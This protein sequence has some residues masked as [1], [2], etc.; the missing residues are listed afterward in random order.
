M[1][2]NIT[3]IGKRLI[4]CLI[5]ASIIIIQMPIA[6]CYADNSNRKYISIVADGT[7]QTL[8]V[9]EKGGTIFIN[10]EDIPSIARYKTDDNNDKTISYLLGS[11]SIV[12]NK[13]DGNY[14]VY[15]LYQ[16]VMSSKG[17][18]SN[19]ISNE[20]GFFIPLAEILPWLNTNVSDAE[21]K[22]ILS[23]DTYSIWELVG[24]DVNRANCYN[25]MDGMDLNSGWTTAG[26]VTLSTIH[27]FFNVK[28]Q[29]FIPM[30]VVDS[31]YERTT[32]LYDVENYKACLFD[33]AGDD[34]L[35][36]DKV[37]KVM[38]DVKNIGKVAGTL[39]EMFDIDDADRDNVASFLIGLRESTDFADITNNDVVDVYGAW[40]KFDDA[41]Q[42]VTALGDAAG[43][44]GKVAGTASKVLESAKKIEIVQKA[45]PDYYRAMCYLSENVSD[46]NHTLKTTADDTKKSL[47]SIMGT[48]MRD[49]MSKGE[50]LITKGLE[51]GIGGEFAAITS[52]IKAGLNVIY[53]S[54]VKAAE[55]TD[56]L[57]IYSDV[58][59]ESRS[60]ADKLLYK[61]NP[62]VVDIN[63]ARALLEV[64]Y[65]A[66]KSGIKITDSILTSIGKDN[67]LSEKVDLVEDELVKT[68][69]TA[70]SALNDSAEGKE[71]YTAE[72]EKVLTKID[73]L[74]MPAI[75]IDSI[76]K[77]YVGAI[78][79]QFIGV[80]GTVSISE[81]PD[82]DII[83][84]TRGMVDIS[85]AVDGARNILP[86]EPVSSYKDGMW[87][88]SWDLVK[89]E[90][91][92]EAAER[93]F[94]RK[95]SRDDITNAFNGVAGYLDPGDNSYTYKDKDDK[96]IDVEDSDIL[97]SARNGRGHYYEVV[98]DNVGA[99]KDS[100]NVDYYINGKDYEGNTLADK[101]VYTAS[102]EFT[103]NSNYPYRLVS[104]K[105]DKSSVY[106]KAFDYLGKTFGQIESE[107]GHLERLQG[108]NGAMYY[109]TTD[110]RRIGFPGSWGANGERIEDAP[111]TSYMG[112][113]DE[114]INVPKDSSLT[115]IAG[116]I[117]YYFSKDELQYDPDNDMVNVVILYTDYQG[118]EYKLIVEYNENYIPTI[119][120]LTFTDR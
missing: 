72:I 5:V 68:A 8:V 60:F 104:I 52:V 45:A 99:E 55:G 3:R 20:D 90:D 65:I 37:N 14:G 115:D 97:V 75:T 49:A 54:F 11:K 95:I 39:A 27:S 100:I 117:G 98:I 79:S 35:Y 41:W 93:V 88:G 91:Y 94:S 9:L 22:L 21:G 110:S 7:E 118:Q 66:S 80:D 40:T 6:D 17:K 106:G 103:G 81:L 33:M 12:I 18:F 38:K 31:R 28:W 92:T 116:T 63:N 85:Y 34:T 71:K 109:T 69:L 51:K 102:F 4:C 25:I 10:A 108:W 107:Y 64:S 112:D 24:Y 76:D 96:T 58:M 87:D 59:D 70:D 119:V 26:L 2:T 56:K 13:K 47:E 1:I 73:I 44:A 19:V 46:D 57:G 62:T 77:E 16:T 82:E 48:V 113:I 111:C 30:T 114:I 89:G 53:P 61:E 67:E 101:V 50:S 36:S 23:S 42:G 43:E 105:R 84:A 86:F 32:T 83:S 15:V 74:E 78:V 120:T 29:R